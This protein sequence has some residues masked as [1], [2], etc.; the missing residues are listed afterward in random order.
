MRYAGETAC[1]TKGKSFACIGGTGFSL[2]TP[3][4]GRISFHLLSEGLPWPGSKRLCRNPLAAQISPPRCSDWCIPRRSG[5]LD[6]QALVQG[7][8]F[9]VAHPL[10]GSRR[11]PVKLVLHPHARQTLADQLFAAG[12]EFP[13]GGES[14]CGGCKVR[15][16][17]GEVPVTAGMR[18]ALSEQEIREGWRLACRALSAGS[19]VVEVEQW[20]PRVLTDEARLSP[21]E[22]IEPRAGRGAAIDLGTTTLVV[23]V[24]DLATG[25]VLRVETALN[26]QAR[27]GA[28]VMSRLQYDLRHPGELGRVIRQALG[29]M[30]GGEPLREVG[31]HQRGGDA[32]PK[33]VRALLGGSRRRGFAFCHDPVFVARPPKRRSRPA[34]SAIAPS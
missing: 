27:Y 12:V 4:C 22:P 2:S 15:V 31:Q 30:L 3:A 29:Q 28:D 11:P 8:H 19:V 6:W 23:Q 33:I 16:L 26:P 1:A 7:F 32:H 17:E 10:Q 13:C 9:Y 14:A 34:N 5:S 20:S 18:D 25:E 24:V 21:L